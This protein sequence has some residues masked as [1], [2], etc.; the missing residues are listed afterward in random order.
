MVDRGIHARGRKVKT[1][2]GSRDTGMCVM[3]WVLGLDGV[4]AII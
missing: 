2:V 4:L 3:Q 1:R